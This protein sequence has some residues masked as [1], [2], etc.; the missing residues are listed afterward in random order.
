MYRVLPVSQRGYYAWRKRPESA[1]AR[2]KR[3]L[4][5]RI[6]VI[7]AQRRRTYGVRR[8]QAALAE[9][10]V[11]CGQHRVARLRRS[12]GWQGK[13]RARHR[14]RTTHSDLT[15][16][17]AP[18]VLNRSFSA[19]RPNQ[20]WLADLTSIDPPE[21]YLYL[22]GVVDVFSRRLVGWARADPMREDL[23]EAALR[24]ALVQRQPDRALLHHSDQASQYTSDGYLS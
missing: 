20:K 21:G 11:V 2:T 24:M 9:P 7:H 6:Q 12:A 22:A 14:P 19:D 4:S 17:A 13:G 5:Q 16:A 3:A 18:N 1:R 8:I 15:R 10:S 23:V